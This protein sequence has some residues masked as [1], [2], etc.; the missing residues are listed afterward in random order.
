MPY[1]L[2]TAYKN[3]IHLVCPNSRLKLDSAKIDLK[4]GKIKKTN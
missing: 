2:S 3:T 1:N 4:F